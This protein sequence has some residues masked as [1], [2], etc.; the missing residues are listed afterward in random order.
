MDDWRRGLEAALADDDVEFRPAEPLA[1]HTSFRIGGDA[2]LMLEVRAEPALA[3][4]LGFCHEE[5]VDCRVLG[6]GTNVLVSDQGLAGVVVRLGGAL[7]NVS[8]VSGAAYP[9]SDGQ[10]SGFIEAGAGARLDDVV[11]AVQAAGLGGVEFLAGIPGTVGGALASNAGAFGRC[12]ADVIVE[13]SGLDRVGRPWRRRR[14]E[15]TVRYREPLIDDG[16][17]AT[18]VRFRLEPVSS[19]GQTADQVRQRRRAIHPP[20]PSAGSFFKN[21]ESRTAG[22]EPRIPAARLIEEC[23]LKGRSVGG[24]RVSMKHANFIVNAGG[25]RCADVYELAQIVKATVEEKT[26]ILLE[27]EVRI[28]PGMAQPFPRRQFNG[29]S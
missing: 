14:E 2:E 6:R 9:R 29:K 12:I 18:R 23:G 7:A 26:G 11:S 28:L 1:R 17:V 25:A 21:P 16:L 5:L 3:R 27:E 24:A 4:V 15:L 20:E 22:S 8:P 13:V 19:Q 10:G